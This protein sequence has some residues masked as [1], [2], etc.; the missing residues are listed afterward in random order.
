MKAA[1]HALAQNRSRLHPQRCADLNVNELRLQQWPLGGGDLGYGI[2]MNSSFRGLKRL[3]KA[4]KVC[5]PRS[6]RPRSS[7]LLALWPLKR[8]APQGSKMKKNA[9]E[10]PWSPWLSPA[11]SLLNHPGTIGSPPA[12]GTRLNSKSYEL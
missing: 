9:S 3:E 12:S 1:R 6:Q 7:K 10:P 4:L 5:P 11:G 2:L 8:E